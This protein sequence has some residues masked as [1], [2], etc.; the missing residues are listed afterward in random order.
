M[1]VLPAVVGGHRAI[2]E[3]HVYEDIMELVGALR[4]GTEPRVP[5][6]QARHVID[7]VESGYRANEAGKTQ[8]LTTTFRWP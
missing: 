2:P 8:D 5:A 1:C 6:D 7:I 3:S 4:N